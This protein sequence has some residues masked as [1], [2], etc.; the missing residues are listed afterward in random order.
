MKNDKSTSNIPHLLF[1][2]FDEKTKLESF[3][4]RSVRQQIITMIKQQMYSF[5][6]PT[7]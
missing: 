6:Q 1:Q 2:I 7:R 5:K 3:N 4:V